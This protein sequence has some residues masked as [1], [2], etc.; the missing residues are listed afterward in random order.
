[1][2]LPAVRWT[3]SPH[4]GRVH[5]LAS[6]E[7]DVAASRGWAEAMCGLTLPGASRAVVDDPYGPLCM[8]CV[9][10]VT[11]DLPDPGPG[12]PPLL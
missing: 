2:S 5:A 10:A 8:P 11:S 3:E 6:T 7:A 1:M 9:V 12:G 4:D